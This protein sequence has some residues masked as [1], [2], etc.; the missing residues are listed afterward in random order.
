MT[1]FKKHTKPSE[2]SWKI[3][4]KIAPIPEE[5]L[6]RSRVNKVSPLEYLRVGGQFFGRYFRTVGWIF[7]SGILA[8]TLVVVFTTP[9]FSLK[10]EKIEL[11]LEPEPVFD[12]TA[13]MTLLREFS[14]KNIFRLTTSEIFTSL[15][16][17]IRHIQSVEK[18]LLL[19]D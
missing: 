3:S 5:I 15:Q 6:L 2:P 12:R 9:F 10:S 13:I 1:W 14:G 19:P 8:L 16:E 18:T 17:N 7:L 4:T 11:A